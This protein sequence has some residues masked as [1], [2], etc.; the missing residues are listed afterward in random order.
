MLTN[1]VFHICIKISFSLLNAL[2]CYLY[3]QR[4]KDIASS[5]SDTAT[6]DIEKLFVFNNFP[7]HLRVP[8]QN[9]NPRFVFC[10]LNDDSSNE[11]TLRRVYDSVREHFVDLHATTTVTFSTLIMNST[12]LKA[13]PYLAKYSKM[14]TNKLA[15]QMLPDNNA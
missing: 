8:F 3:S 7:E 6:Q 5:I 12:Q 11:D 10:G 4:I 13:L 14:F 2:G 15:K 1:N 9:S